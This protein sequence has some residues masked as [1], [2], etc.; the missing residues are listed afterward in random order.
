MPAPC[1]GFKLFQDTGYVI[2]GAGDE[3]GLAISAEFD[4]GAGTNGV[5]LV[6]NVLRHVEV[7][8]G[9]EAELPGVSNGPIDD[10]V[11]QFSRARH[12]VFLPVDSAD[13]IRGIR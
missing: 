7:F 1:R 11:G 9:L 13:N 2:I 8:L 3:Q 6:Q 4:L 5:G 10:L 12:R